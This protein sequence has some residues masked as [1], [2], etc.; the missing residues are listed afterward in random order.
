M[1]NYKLYKLTV[2]GIKVTLFGWIFLANLYAVG[3]HF[4]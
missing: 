4:C 3:S 1:K 2:S